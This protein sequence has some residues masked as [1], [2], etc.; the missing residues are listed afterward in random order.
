M[1]GSGSM[2]IRRN[3]AGSGVVVWGG[4][5]Y[6]RAGLEGFCAALQGLPGLILQNQTRVFQTS[7]SA[8]LP[9]IL[10]VQLV[11]PAAAPTSPRKLF[12]W[13]G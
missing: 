12:L 2:M 7:Y 9:D 10:D 8:D 13:L 1:Q 3:Q 6:V 4:G 5:G 11:H